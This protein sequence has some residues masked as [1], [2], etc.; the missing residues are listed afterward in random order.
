[1]LTVMEVR[2]IKAD[3]KEDITFPSENDGELH[4]ANGKE[5][6][7]LPAELFDKKGGVKVRTN[8]YYASLD[9]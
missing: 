1:M 6:I 3:H 7:F 4:L 9:K 5:R 2:R 8:C